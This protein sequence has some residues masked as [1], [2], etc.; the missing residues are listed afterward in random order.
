LTP[1]ADVRSGRGNPS[2]LGRR[3]QHARFIAATSVEVPSEPGM[4]AGLAVFQ[5]ERHHYFAGVRRDANGVSVFLERFRGRGSAQEIVKN[6]SL[7]D[8]K[9]VKLRV[10]AE[11]GKC[12]FEYA[13]DESSWETLAA[14]QDATLL[15]TDVAG[16]FVGATVGP[17][18]RLEPSREENQP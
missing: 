17:H 8:A 18:A 14:D 6:V 2:F 7:P 5:G 3:V 11:D 1:R 10:V 16:G 12:A 15:T 9:N 4:S 13:G